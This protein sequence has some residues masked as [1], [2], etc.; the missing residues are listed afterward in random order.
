MDEDMTRQNVVIGN[1]FEKAIGFSRAVRVGKWIAVSGTAPI[2][3]DGSVA[4]PGDVYGQT[5]KCFEIILDAVTRAGGSKR[6]VRRTRVF[7]T[8][9]ERWQDAARAHGEIFADIQPACTFVEVS[10]F[11]NP[12]WLV[13]IEADAYVE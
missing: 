8:D 5:L 12:D 10:R 9:M 2:A 6:T 1:P 4:C 11:I 3:E 7:T 13:E